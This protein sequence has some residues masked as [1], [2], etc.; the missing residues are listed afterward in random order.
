MGNLAVYTTKV[1]FLTEN[2]PLL[3]QETAVVMYSIIHGS[4]VDTK[5]NYS[6][7]E[8]PEFS[9]VNGYGTSGVHLT[10]ALQ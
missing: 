10:V 6:P 2:S 1:L 3:N 8:I 7:V 5:L 9:A 4:T